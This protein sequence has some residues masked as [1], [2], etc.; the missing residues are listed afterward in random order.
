MERKNL[1]HCTIRFL[2]NGEPTVLFLKDIPYQIYADQEGGRKVELVNGIFMIPIESISYYEQYE[3]LPERTLL[4]YFSQLIDQVYEAEPDE[5][6]RLDISRIQQK[7]LSEKWHKW[8]K[9]GYVSDDDPLPSVLYNM[10]I[11]KEKKKS[12]WG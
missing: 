6:M 3:D 11:I 12:F 9:K 5:N 8:I 7:L 2:S 1:N 10:G 4:H